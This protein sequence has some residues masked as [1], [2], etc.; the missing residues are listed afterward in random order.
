MINDWMFNFNGIYKI[1]EKLWKEGMKSSSQLYEK[2]QFRKKT[3]FKIMIVFSRSISLV[4][5]FGL[6]IH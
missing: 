3:K 2:L 4:L 1:W 5:I 6:D